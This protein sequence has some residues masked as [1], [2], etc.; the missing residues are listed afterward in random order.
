MAYGYVNC[1][2]LYQSSTKTSD[3]SEY[4]LI[5]DTVIILCHDIQ[6]NYYKL[7]MNNLSTSLPLLRHLRS[8]NILVLGTLRLKRVPG[9]Q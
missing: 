9:I 2:E 1:F 7:F 4:G 3:R 5:E 6:I 8:H